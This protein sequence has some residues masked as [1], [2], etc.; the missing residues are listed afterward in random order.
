MALA[1]ALLLVLAAACDIRSHRIPNWLTLAGLAVGLAWHGWQGGGPGWLM[2][3]EG[4][5]VA[6]LALLPYAVRGL[7]AGDVKL[8]GAVG[9][10]LG[11]VFLLWTLL[12]T[13]LAGGLL[14]LGWAAMRGT[15]R[16]GRDA[17]CP[18]HCARRGVCLCPSA[19]EACA[20]KRRRQRGAALVEFALVSGLLCCCCSGSLRWACCFRI[21]PK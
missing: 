18:G 9:A 13:I 21:K 10:L 8:L 16:A 1:L 19:S 12:G 14:A 17:A 20:M 4:I 2:S 7:G 15:L 6:G 3:L 5:G 11:P